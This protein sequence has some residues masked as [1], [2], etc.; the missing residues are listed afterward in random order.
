MHNLF[1]FDLFLIALSGAVVLVTGL[2]GAVVVLFRC[3]RKA[4]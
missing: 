2:V 1:M 3:I 4:V